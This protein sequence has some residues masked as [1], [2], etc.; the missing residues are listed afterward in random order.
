MC[1]PSVGR[2]ISKTDAAR[3]NVDATNKVVVKKIG[4]I[5]KNVLKSLSVISA[6]RKAAIEKANG[7]ESEDVSI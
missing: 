3:L 7:G 6:F 2:E 4:K 5:K 1:F